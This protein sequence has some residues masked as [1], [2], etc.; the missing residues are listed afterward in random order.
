MLL[1]VLVLYMI[2]AWLLRGVTVSDGVEDLHYGVFQ[3]VVQARLISQ[4]FPCNDH[5]GSGA[6][7]K[8]L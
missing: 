6:V 8:Q 2:P 4:H 5:G 3:H 7:V 1:S